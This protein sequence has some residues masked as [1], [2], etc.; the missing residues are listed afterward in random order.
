MISVSPLLWGE[1]SSSGWAENQHWL[2][3][4]QTRASPGTSVQYMIESGYV[5]K[6][7][8]PELHKCHGPDRHIWKP[9]AENVQIFTSFNDGKQHKSFMQRESS[10]ILNKVLLYILVSHKLVGKVVQGRCW[11]VCGAEPSGPGQKGEFLSSVVMVNLFAKRSESLAPFPAMIPDS[12]QTGL[13]SQAA[14]F[15]WDSQHQRGFQWAEPVPFSREF[16]W[17][18]L[19]AE[20]SSSSRSSPRSFSRPRC[21]S[22]KPGL[23]LRI[24]GEFPFPGNKHPW[25]NAQI[26]N[27]HWANDA[28]SWEL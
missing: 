21:G 8:L 14:G 1:K 24:A 23:C 6:Y 16:C 28:L 20:L 18:C 22:S 3:N 12:P 2:P 5:D 27:T 11:G 15:P 7:R 10:I 26:A 25:R 13:S 9:L 4:S 19:L 17:K